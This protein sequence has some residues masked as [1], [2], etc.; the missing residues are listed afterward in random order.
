MKDSEV[1][2]LEVKTPTK[3]ST[4]KV[5]EC[6]EIDKQFVLREARG[7]N[8]WKTDMEIWVIKISVDFGEECN[9]HQTIMHPRAQTIMHPRVPNRS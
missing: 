9:C 5:I 1:R 7:N 4:G 8:R 6:D 2:D 3:N